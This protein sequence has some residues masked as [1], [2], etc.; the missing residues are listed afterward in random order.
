[1]NL[2]SYV[3]LIRRELKIISMLNSDIYCAKQYLLVSDVQIV[4]GLQKYT[5]QSARRTFFSENL[6]YLHF[7]S[8]SSKNNNSSDQFGEKSKIFRLK[9]WTFLRKII[10]KIDFEF[11]NLEPHP[12]NRAS[13]STNPFY[14]LYIRGSHRFDWSIGPPLFA[15]PRDTIT[16]ARHQIRS[17]AII[18]H[19]M[20]RTGLII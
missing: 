5:A 17:P 18:F 7:L 4:K 12:E 10:L 20:R 16:W 19:T 6:L 9:V 2:D 3:S 13:P 8:S 1:M 15:K 11:N 14:L